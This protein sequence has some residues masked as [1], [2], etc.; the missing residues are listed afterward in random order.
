MRLYV[1]HSLLA[2]EKD[3]MRLPSSKGVMTHFLLVI[4]RDVMTKCAMLLTSCCSKE[5]I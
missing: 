2:V 1:T 3:M 4:G 5:K